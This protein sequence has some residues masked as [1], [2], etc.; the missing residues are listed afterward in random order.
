MASASDNLVMMTI[1]AQSATKLMMAF[2]LWG[3]VPL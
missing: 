2:V 1:A 3:Q